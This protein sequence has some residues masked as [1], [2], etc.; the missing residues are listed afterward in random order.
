M[1]HFFSVPTWQMTW[2]VLNSTI[3][4]AVVNGTS[5]NANCSN[6]RWTLLN[7][8][9]DFYNVYD[10]FDFHPGP[11]DPSSF[12][13]PDGVFCKGFKGANKT[14]PKFPPV[15]SI[16]FEFMSSQRNTLMS[17]QVSVCLDKFHFLST[18][19]IVQEF[20]LFFSERSS[21]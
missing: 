16:E 21:S 18:K 7:G 17:W 8:T 10:F 13:L 11:Q 4:R 20:M 15:F 14:L 12:Q 2:G 9:H 1:D 5:V 3:V 19:S 6:G